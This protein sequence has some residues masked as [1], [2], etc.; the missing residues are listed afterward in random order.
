MDS[1][2]ELH[3]MSSSFDFRDEWVTGNSELF[4]EMACCFLVNKKHVFYFHH[5]SLPASG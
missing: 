1:K 4:Y 2:V 3:Q 5:L